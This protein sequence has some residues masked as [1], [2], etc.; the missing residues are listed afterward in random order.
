[1][2]VEVVE[3][4]E[5]EEGVATEVVVEEGIEG[6]GVATEVVVEEGIVI[7][8]AATEEVMEEEV[9]AAE[10]VVVEEA[11]EEEEEEEEECK[12]DR[13]ESEGRDW[14]AITTLPIGAY[15]VF[16]SSGG[17]QSF[18]KSTAGTSINSSGLYLANKITPLCFKLNLRLLILF[19]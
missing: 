8:G 2:E 19:L 10:L 6:E 13:M 1:M 17:V 9:A 14:V 11:E 3:G 15:V 7:E 18:P 16:S 5:G 12:A 4:E